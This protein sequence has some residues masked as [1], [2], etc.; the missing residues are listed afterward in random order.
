[1]SKELKNQAEQHEH[2]HSHEHHGETCCGGHDHYDCCHDE[3]SCDDDS[4]ARL[5]KYAPWVLG[6]IILLGLFA[7]ILMRG[8]AVLTQVK[9]LRN[10]IIASQQVTEAR[11]VELEKLTNHALETFKAIDAKLAGSAAV[12]DQALAAVKE[13]RV[14][15]KETSDALKE[16]LSSKDSL[17][18]E[19]INKTRSD[20]P[21]PASN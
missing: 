1:M 15:F 19:I 4:S 11:V 18:R 14:I 7:G 20:A 8:D 12:N 9:E 17:I 5:K 13:M 21:A 2:E 3:I 6:A 10:E 16:A